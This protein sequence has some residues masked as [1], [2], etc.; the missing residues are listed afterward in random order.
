MS[1]EEEKARYLMHQNSIED[2]DYVRFLN[3]VL[4]PMLPYLDKTMRG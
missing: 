4:H 3:R 1:P 2:D